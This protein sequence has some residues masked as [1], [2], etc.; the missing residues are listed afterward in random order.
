MTIPPEIVD[1]IIDY[2]HNDPKTL[3][4]C[5]LVA[6]DWVTSAHFH[7]F[8]KMSIL[9]EDDGTKLKELVNFSPN[10]L[11]H[12]QELTMGVINGFGKTPVPAGFVTF[13]EPPLTLPKRIDSFTSLRTLHICGLPFPPMDFI[14]LLVA[15]SQK[16]TTINIT[17]C[18]FESRHDLWKILRLFPNLQHVHASDLGYS[19]SGEGKLAIPPHRCH[20]PPIVSFSFYTHCMGFVLEELAEPPYPL[21]HLKSLEIRH[22]DQ[23]QEKLDSIATKYQDAITTLKF[24]ANSAF[25][26]GVFILPPSIPRRSQSHFTDIPPHIGLYN[27]LQTLILGKLEFFAAYPLNHRTS[28]TIPCF[29]WVATAIEQIKSRLNRLVFEIA[30]TKRRDLDA[31]YWEDVDEFLNSHEQFEDLEAVDVVFLDTIPTKVTWQPHTLHPGVDLRE[32]I[33]KR[34]RRTVERGLMRCSTR[35]LRTQW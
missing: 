14:E 26:S 17:E 13:V 19:F 2:V 18:S 23:R 7:L 15:V 35:G 1:Y 27:C 33:M 11:R 24:G 20:S 10:L 16:V 30:V 6:R 22:T 4:A 31:I 29:S 5:S 34:M 12:C 3:I 8:T 9:T 32:D 21:T 25:G 28:P